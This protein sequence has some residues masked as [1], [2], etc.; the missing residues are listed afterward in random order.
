MSDELTRLLSETLH[1]RVDDVES[2]PDLTA[3]VLSKGRSA[4]RR[5]LAWAGAPLVS[6]PRLRWSP[7]PSWGRLCSTRPTQDPQTVVCRPRR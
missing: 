5:R 2:M 4:R 1:S 7:L 6:S 3:R